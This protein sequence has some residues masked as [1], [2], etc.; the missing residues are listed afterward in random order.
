MGLGTR[1]AGLLTPGL[2]ALWGPAASIYTISAL[3]FSMPHTSPDAYIPCRVSAALGDL[4]L[5]T[6]DSAIPP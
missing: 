2:P 4:V 3:L 1:D 6:R 5:C